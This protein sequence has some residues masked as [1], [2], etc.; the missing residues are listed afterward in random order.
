MPNYT[1]VDRVY[2]LEP[3]VGSLADLTSAQL[4]STF[5]DTAEAEMNARLARRYTVPISGT[6][7]LLQAVADDIAVYRVLSRRM[8]TQDQLKDSVWP[9]RF[10]ESLETL[11]EIASGKVLLVDDS[12]AVVSTLGTV[13]SAKTNVEAYLPT[14]HE[15]GGW[16]D[17]V[18]DPDKVDDLLDERDL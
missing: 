16:L 8:F 11:N 18:K 15:G 2:D 9:D 17:Q 5:I 6:I 14:F 3:L 12:G 10:K 1:S 7:P 13:V 4:L